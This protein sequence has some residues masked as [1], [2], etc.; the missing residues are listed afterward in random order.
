MSNNDK[1]AN[2]NLSTSSKATRIVFLVLTI[3]VALFVPMLLQPELNIIFRDMFNPQG[4][5]ILIPKL[6]VLSTLVCY[7]ITA[8]AGVTALHFSKINKR[9]L[10]ILFFVLTFLW[11]VFVSFIEMIVVTD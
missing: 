5:N 11:T 8:V 4:W 1:E 3:V 10:T 9:W 6:R 2:N 7:A